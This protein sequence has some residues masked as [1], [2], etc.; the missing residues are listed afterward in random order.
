[1]SY[2]TRRERNTFKNTVDERVQ[3]RSREF[4]HNDFSPQPRPTNTDIGS[5]V[6]QLRDGPLRMIDA[7]IA[8][9]QHRREAILGEN[10]RMQREISAYAKLNQSTMDSTRIISESLA[11]FAADAPAMNE[12]AEAVSDQGGR[13][14]ASEEFA[15]SKGTADASRLLKTRAIPQECDPEE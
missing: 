6:Q 13:K 5:S 1:M 8:E 3:T 7:V 12:L 10:L 14:G 9:L 11:N 2:L 15:E 4:S